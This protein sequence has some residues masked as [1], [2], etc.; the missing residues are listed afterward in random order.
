[1]KTF[2]A[3]THLVENLDSVISDK[4]ILRF[5]QDN[6]ISNKELIKLIDE[7]INSDKAETH[8]ESS[9]LHNTMFSMWLKIILFKYLYQTLKIDFLELYPDSY[10]ADSVKRL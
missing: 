9:C 7:F 2:F 4:M 10:W 3:N 1:M 5:I 6:I 8:K